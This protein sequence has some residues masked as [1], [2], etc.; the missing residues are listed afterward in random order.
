MSTTEWFGVSLPYLKLK[1]WPTH[2]QFNTLENLQQLREFHI[3]KMAW[4]ITGGVHL[5]QF[6]SSDGCESKILG[7][8][9]GD[10]HKPNVTPELHQIKGDDIRSIK[11]CWNEDSLRGIIFLDGLGKVIAGDYTDFLL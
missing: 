8:T 6:G 1:E 2:E 5:L 3:T 7:G 4:F 11:V 10:W 9:Y